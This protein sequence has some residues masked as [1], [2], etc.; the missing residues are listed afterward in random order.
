MSELALRLNHEPTPL[1]TA[2]EELSPEQ[3]MLIREREITKQIKE[4]TAIQKDLRDQLMKIHLETG[5]SFSNGVYKLA[6]SKRETLTWD[7]PAIKA[8]LPKAYEMCLSFDSAKAKKL[9]GIVEG[10]DEFRHVETKLTWHVA[11]E[12]GK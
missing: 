10:L 7:E 1:E 3:K 11:K 9:L 2:G 4:L 8:Q 12:E 5:D 6:P